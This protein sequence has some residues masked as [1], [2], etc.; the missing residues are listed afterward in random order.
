MHAVSLP[1][2][3]ML[4]AMYLLV[5]VGLGLMVLPQLPG[6]WKLGF[7]AAIVKCMLAAFWALC[8]LGLRYPLQMIPVLLWELAWKALWIG[9]VALPKWLSGDLDA[10]TEANFYACTLV[11]LVPIV[12]PW[13]YVLRHYVRQAGAPW[14]SSG[15]AMH[16][17][18][19]RR[20]A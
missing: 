5:V 13:G 17:T 6:A 12:M 3:Y 2:L 19:S 11:V 15:A 4:R 9:I 20:A 1:R 16:A 7:D 8:L 10:D 18:P 14:T